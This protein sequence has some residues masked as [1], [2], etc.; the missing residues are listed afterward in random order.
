MPAYHPKAEKEFDDILRLAGRGIKVC[1][2]LMIQRHLRIEDGTERLSASEELGA[3]SGTSILFEVV[4]SYGL[5]MRV[6]C[7]Y[8]RQGT[9]VTVLAIDARQGLARLGM[10]QSAPDARARAWGRST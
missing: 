3:G 6:L 8:E 7:V 2:G 9:V 4:Y 5:L 1:L 10:P